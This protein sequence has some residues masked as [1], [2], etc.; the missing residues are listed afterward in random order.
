MANCCDSMLKYIVFLFNFLFF[1]TGGLLI[2]IGAYAQ[3][4]LKNYFDFLGSPYLNASIIFIIIG[5]VIL[6]VAFFGCCGA[7][8][9]N[10]CMLYTY[11]TL[12]ALI[13]LV[14][15]GLAVTVYVFRGDA[16]EFVSKGMRQGM[17]NYPVNEEEGH[18][19]VKDTWDAIQFDLKCCGVEY[20]ADWKETKFGK[21]GNVPDSCCKES[22][23]NCGH[24]ILNLNNQTAATTIYTEG[25]FAK[26]ESVVLSNVGPVA[27]IGVGVAVFQVLGVIVSCFLA[28]N[29]RRKDNYV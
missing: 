21:D 17:L 13:L 7:C 20:F 28:A 5:C 11:A 22:T 16:R 12:M 2:G 1:I 14:E 10:A 3:I 4:K 9:E 24:G 25:C 18:V 29:M 26:F 27:G 19:G 15:I 6:V 8:T 23:L